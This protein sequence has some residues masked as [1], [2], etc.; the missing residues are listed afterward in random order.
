MQK[1]EFISKG[2]VLIITF[3]VLTPIALATSLYALFSISPNP[4]RPEVLSATTN[5]L[6]NPEFGVQIYA[7]L[8]GNTPSITINSYATDARVEILRQYLDRYN[9]PLLPYARDLVAAADRYNL[10]FRLLP[11]IAQQESNLCKR[12]P[13]NSHNCW[14]W[15][16]HSA[17]TLRF[18]D[19]ITAINAVASGIKNEYFDKGYKTVDQIMD[20][21]VPHSPQRAWAKGV[22]SFM[23]EM[24]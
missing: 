15:G 17:G 14:G 10:D 1:D 24:E 18:P 6:E 5:I 11:A 3:F 20:K 13:V 8:P 4:S 7:S 23:A 2:L 21:W 16:I 22:K 12:I 9:S 19:Y